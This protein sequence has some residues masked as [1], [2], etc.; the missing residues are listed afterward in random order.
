MKRIFTL[1]FVVFAGTVSAQHLP[2]SAQPF[3]FAP[4][5]N[6]AFTGIENYGDLKLAYRSVGCV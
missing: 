1:I 3:Q 2:G 5:F 4:L 6:P